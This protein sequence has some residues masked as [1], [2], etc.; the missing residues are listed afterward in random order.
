MANKYSQYY[1]LAPD[2]T[3]YLPASPQNTRPGESIFLRGIVNVTAATD[4]GYIAPVVAGLR[5]V[6]GMIT[7]SATNGSLTATLGWSSDPDAIASLTTQVQS[8][9]ATLL[10]PAQLKALANLSEDDDSLIITFG[11]TWS[12][13][14]N[15]GVYLQLV[16]TGS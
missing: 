16:N 4:V 12:T 9:T 5:P 13:A 6:Y 1:T 8:D 14:T 15:V 11:G 2:G 10:T 3:N 7:A